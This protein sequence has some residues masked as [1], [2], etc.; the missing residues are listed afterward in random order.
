MIIIEI[1]MIPYYC[2]LV[3]ITAFGILFHELG[4]YLFYRFYGYKPSIAIK[5]WGIV[6]G[7][8]LG[9]EVTLKQLYI[10]AGSGIIMGLPFFLWSFQ[11]QIMYWFMCAIDL[12]IMIQILFTGRKYKNMKIIEYEQIVVKEYLKKRPKILQEMRKN[13]I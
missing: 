3:I 8:N 6:L 2:A 4:H 12:F 11:M 10:I 5:W 13:D 9:K 1:A 7:E